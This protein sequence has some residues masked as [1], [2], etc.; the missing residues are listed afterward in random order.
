MDTAS[1]TAPDVGRKGIPYRNW[2]FTVFNPTQDDEARIVALK[3]KAIRL[4]VGRETCPTSGTPHL[5]G[6]IR[7]IKAQ[8][9]TTVVNA[10]KPGCH[11]ELRKGTE[12]EAST[13]A[14]KDGNVLVDHGVDADRGKGLKRSRD[15]E[16]DEIIEEIEKG[17]KYGAIRNRH[18]RFFFWHRRFVLGFMHD[19][20]RL[21]SD[22]DHDP[23]PCFD[24]NR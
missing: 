16:T 15:E 6:Y 22:P 10:I 18:K 14:L 3:D 9:F 2:C 20:R 19:H 24:G 11:L 5:Q 13:Y 12:S 21:A 23:S 8:K 17:E 1:T 7:F 4:A